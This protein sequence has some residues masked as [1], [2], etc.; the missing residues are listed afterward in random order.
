VLL[1]DLAD[2]GPDT[3]GVFRLVM[4]M[5]AAGTAL[6]VLGNHEVKL[7]HALTRKDAKAR[8][9]Q[10]RSLAQLAEQPATFREAVETFI[11]GL[12][13]QHVLDGGRL[14]VC[15]AGVPERFH[16]EESKSARRFCLHGEE[17]GDGVAPSPLNA[18]WVGEY[19][20]P[21]MVVYGHTPVVAPEWV[22]N[23]LCV[24]TGC[25]YG[26]W[27]T[28]LR[29][30]ERALESVPAAHVYARPKLPF[31]ANPRATSAVLPG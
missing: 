29:Y 5:A 19:Q 2:R 24:D 21:A 17:T 22:N 31:A 20:G 6:G 27:L 3:P 11:R 14:V 26:G 8:P 28:A 13:P 4:G 23:T 10:A 9:G 18:R 12:R 16:G 1:G 30:P 7:L 25:V 15:H